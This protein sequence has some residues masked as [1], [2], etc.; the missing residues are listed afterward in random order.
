[1]TPDQRLSEIGR[2]SLLVDQRFYLYQKRCFIFFSQR[3]Q[4]FSHFLAVL[5]RIIY[6]WNLMYPTFFLRTIKD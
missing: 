6:Q 5:N 1:M 2:I 3:I 4:I